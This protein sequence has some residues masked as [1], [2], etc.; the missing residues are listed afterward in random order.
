MQ[1]QL[2]APALVLLRLPC[3]TATLAALAKA[4]P[5]RASRLHAAILPRRLLGHNQIQD[6]LPESW[7]LGIF[8]RLQVL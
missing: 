6:V 1:V 5:S 2:L 8:P 7:G 4:P 3:S